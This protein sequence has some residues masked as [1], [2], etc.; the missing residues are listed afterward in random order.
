MASNVAMLLF[1][2]EQKL[3]C[4]WISETAHKTDQEISST[5]FYFVS[6]FMEQFL[7]RIY[8][9]LITAIYS[10]SK[11]DKRPSMYNVVGVFGYC[12]DG[13][14]DDV[15]WTWNWVAAHRTTTH[16]YTYIVPQMKHFIAQAINITFYVLFQ[17]VDK[18]YKNKNINNNECEIEKESEKKKT[19]TIPRIS[20]YLWW[21]EVKMVKL[22]TWY[23]IESWGIR[24]AI[25]KP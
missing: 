25:V 17:S 12:V 9:F 7:S 3:W 10:T 1:R 23:P 13:N 20:I 5:D 16:I 22:R 14:I 21:R 2:Y 11:I 19:R 4:I 18:A 8:S 6:V 15:K 24:C